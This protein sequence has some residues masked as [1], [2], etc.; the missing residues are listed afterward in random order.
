MQQSMKKCFQ[1]QYNFKQFLEGVVLAALGVLGP[2]LIAAEELG[3]YA[4]LTTAMMRESGSSLLFAAIK[5]VFMNVVRMVPH[6]LGAFLINESVHIYIKGKKIFLFNVMFT[7]SLIVLIY[8]MIYRLYGI[9]YDLGIPALLTIAFV[10]LLSYMDLF[11]V[12]MLNKLILVSSLLLGIQWL[13]VIPMLTEYGFGRGEISMDVKKAAEFIREER[14]LT[15]LASAMCFSFFYTS[16]I[17]VQLLYKEHKLKISNEKTRRMEKELYDA[18]IEALKMRSFSEVQSL[19]HDLKSPLTTIQGLISLAEMMEKDDLIREYFQKIS[20][21]LTTMNMMIS[22][23]LYENV[24]TMLKTEELMQMVLAQISVSVP[25]GMLEYKNECPEALIW[26]NKIR[27]ARAVINLLNN[28][29]TAVD[30]ENGKLELK[31]EC[32]NSQIYITV[33]DNGSGIAADEMKYIWTPGYSGRRS[34]GMGL[35]FTKQ[36]VEN[37]GGI[38]QIESEKGKYT[39]AIICLREGNEDGEHKDNSGN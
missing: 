7:I 19:V 13:D 5:L 34:T 23:I 15:L 29:Y 28:A 4:S 12:S 32:Q 20:S 27:L 24:R 26:G 39:K 30:K 25:S 35:A 10:L 18:Q 3:I 1:I 2:K 33:S 36:V 6:Y 37:H 22:E 11:S 21:S 16:M 17:Q 38:I 9:R 14:L 8:D 31:V